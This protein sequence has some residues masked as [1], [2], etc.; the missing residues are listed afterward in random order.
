MT[1]IVS[2]AK[3]RN[4]IWYLKTGKTKKFVCEYLQISYNV[5]TLNK[6]IT[7]F[8]AKEVR[9][10]ELRKA[11]QKQELTI[12]DKQQIIQQY[13]AGNS[14]TQLAKDFFI[15]L[16]RVKKVLLES[17]V[18]IRSRKG[19]ATSHITENT[20][21]AILPKSTVFCKKHNCYAIVDTVYDEAYLEYL[22]KGILVKIDLYKFTPGKFKQPQLGIHYDW[23]IQLPDG[24]QLKQSAIAAIRKN[25]L[26]CL[27]ETGLEYYRIWRTDEQACYYTVNRSD[28]CL[29]KAN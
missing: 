11:K 29:V 5:N 12:L 22:D 15:S 8:K 20:E 17:N 24:K 18:P 6:L 14:Q 13:L 1:K 21:Q 9:E 25:I 28:I 7:D 19:Y 16:A 26:Q 4:A 3:I 23:Y 10:V 27:S 2:D